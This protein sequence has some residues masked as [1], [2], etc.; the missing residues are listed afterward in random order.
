MCISSPLVIGIFGFSSCGW[1]RMCRHPWLSGI[2]LP[3]HEV[4]EVAPQSED[5]IHSIVER[6]RQR[7]LAKRAS[8]QLKS[9]QSGVSATAAEE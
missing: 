4:L 3:K 1:V 6:A 9:I 7:R 5:D 8:Q 2:P